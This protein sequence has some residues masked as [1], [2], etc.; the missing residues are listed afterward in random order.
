MDV[1][2]W[3]RGLNLGHYEA[4]F[5]ENEID[6]EIL[7][8][9]TADDLKELGVAVV[10]HRR[11]L[12]T[13][14]ASLDRSTQASDRS[15]TSTPGPERDQHDR[16]TAERRQLT[17]M[18]CDLV[19]STALSARLD[20]EDM[21][22]I[23]GAY[24][25]CCAEQITKAGGVVAKY[26]G[27]GVLAYF[28]YPRADEYDAE[29]AV[30]A[31]LALVE[32][33]PKLASVVSTPP[34]VRIGIA[35]G[36]VVVGDLIGTGSARE[37]AVVGD[38]PN[39]AA[40]LQ[41]LAP[42]GGIVVSGST[43]TIAGTQFDYID[44]GKVEI[45]GLREPV[46]VW[47]IAGKAAATSRS[48]ALEGGELLPLI[49][50]DEEMELL[51]RR[52]E[53]AK[54]GDGRVVLLS[55]EPGIGKSRISLSL[56]EQLAGQEKNLVRL[57]CSPY[58]MNSAFYPLIAALEREVGF[59]RRDSADQR[60]G[61]LK[62]WL[63]GLGRPSDVD[64]SLLAELLSIPGIISLPQMSPQE[65]REQ[66]MRTLLGLVPTFA[67]AKPLLVILEDAHWL[68]PTSQELLSRLVEQ[69]RRQPT[70]V[71]VTARP[72][73]QPRWASQP[74]VTV[75]ALNRLGEVDV[76]EIVSLMAGGR[77]I[78]NSIIEQ[79]VAR[80]DGVPLYVEEL[81]K[82]ILETN[83]QLEDD[84]AIA[85]ST[86]PPSLQASLIA[87]LD[88]LSLAKTIAQ[89]GATIGR[90]FSYELLFD[91]AEVEANELRTALDQLVNSGL[92]Y[93]QGEIPDASFTFK[94]ALVQQA[95]YETL[96][97]SRRQQ[98]HARI[99]QVLE[100]RLG[101][102]AETQPELLGRH[103]SEAGLQDRAVKYWLAAGRIATSRGANVEAASHA[104]RGLSEL[105][106]LPLSGNRDSDELNLRVV[107]GTA[108]IATEGYT[109]TTTLENYELARPLAQSAEREEAGDALLSGLFMAYYNC[110]KLRK[111]LE[112][113]QQLLKRAE[114][115]GNQLSMSAGYR[116]VGASYSILGDVR[117]ADEYCRKA[118][119]LSQA[120]ER[121]YVD[122][123][124][125]HD[126]SVSAACQWA[127]TSWHLGRIDQSFELSK[128]ALARVAHLQHP[129]TTG[130][131]ISQTAYWAIFQRDFTDLERYA[132]QLQ[133]LSSPQWVAWGLMCE[134]LFLTHSGKHAMGIEKFTRGLGLVSSIGTDVLLPVFL[135]SLADAQLQ[136]GK[137]PEATETIERACTIANRTE[138]RWMDAELWRLRGRLALASG[139]ASGAAQAEAYFRRGLQTAV[140]QGSKMFALRLTTSLARI[141]AD[142][143]RYEQAH[144]DLAE[145]LSG[146]TG[147][148]NT[149]DVREADAFLSQTTSRGR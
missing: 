137:L 1:G 130:Y 39:L 76:G 93:R 66:L 123:R 105:A 44:L 140:D 145:A 57:F 112:V 128:I 71:L 62:L 30:L 8:T 85:S 28:G 116:Q 29:H 125:V 149:P 3:L 20:P 114:Q 52:W 94:H 74:A 48:Q 46:A 143:G 33:V 15:I 148:P 83:V 104:K 18:F 14:I 58:H 131:G 95:A 55:G 23:L 81:T 16:D 89:I 61:K 63:S 22:D 37:Q 119:E 102:I 80:A 45:K 35:T 84:G 78:P 107:L 73:F 2:V 27:D 120:N 91:I 59:E 133:E 139:G 49:G 132:I 142:Q 77:P 97:R 75:Q 53:R 54:R 6:G 134:G 103:F 13:A 64:I 117:R 135:A 138:E 113:S 100:T 43:K 60:Q 124:F 70:F 86:I 115:A 36:L 40:R 21:R 90:E 118:F 56:M 32:A 65:K 68:D 38:T 67:V 4:A 9:L 144:G 109:A 146:I 82:T 72:E 126:L 122:Y 136:G 147:G 25:R 141:W 87:R 92:V 41:S 111:A 47:Q 24:H 106:L 99:G 79:I 26:M 42:S 51:L 11:K 98:L 121:P 7:P 108:L 19:G 69:V 31:G 10:G 34:Q 101:G 88:R 110:G 96:L 127:R 17:I 129:Q 50:R 12:L 5:R